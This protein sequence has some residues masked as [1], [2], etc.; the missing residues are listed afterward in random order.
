MAQLA[1]VSPQ[2][3]TALK[4]LDGL[5]QRTP[6]IVEA[7]AFYRA[8]IPAL[9]QAQQA[10]PFFTLDPAAAQQKLESGQP[11]LV[12]EDLPL[13]GQATTDFF[14]HLCRLVERAALPD[15]PN[16]SGW[17]LF[18]RGK[19]D[20]ATLMERAEAGDGAALQSAAAGQ[21]R[22]LVEQNQLHL[23]AVWEALATGDALR[24]EQTAV[25]LKLD[26]NLLRVLAQNSLKPAL[27]V[28]AR[29]LC[30]IVDLDHW[31]RGH[32]PMCGNA[33]ALSE[34]QGKEG[35]RRLR[36][37]MC[38]A[39]WYYPRLQC[40]FCGTRGHKT[41]GYI[42]VEGEEEKYRLQTCETC[43]RYIKVVVTFDPI[44]EDLLAVEDLATLHLDHIANERGFSRP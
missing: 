38:G 39:G 24:V 26:P 30:Q 14:L 15:T 33:P 34:I 13:D 6:E 43:R 20:P 7:V 41:L 36:C 12:G 2:I 29:N 4:R 11:L 44:P 1:K 31:R 28:W 3:E 27:R 42:A 5:V 32:C 40:P 19:P 25:H 21:I 35:E 37:A 18:K 9:W 10:V 22:R 16:R 23:A 17:S 8:A